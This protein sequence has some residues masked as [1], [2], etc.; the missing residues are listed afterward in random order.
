MFLQEH[1]ALKRTS[2]FSPL[3]V[4]PNGEKTRPV[5]LLGCAATMET[6][7]RAANLALAG[8]FPDKCSH[9]NA[10]AFADTWT[11]VLCGMLQV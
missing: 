6:H 9:I 7:K 5:H 1:Q 3:V 11:Y 10:L 8:T 4:T 2:E